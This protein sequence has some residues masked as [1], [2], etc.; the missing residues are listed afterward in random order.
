[1]ARSVCPSVLPFYGRV[2]IR[3]GTDGH[4]AAGSG[5]LPV[6]SVSSRI[7]YS[8]VTSRKEPFVCRLSKMKLKAAR[9]WDTGGRLQLDPHYGRDHAKLAVQHSL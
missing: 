2:L 5:P 6:M 4:K 8:L 7:N 9:L 3:L 1:M